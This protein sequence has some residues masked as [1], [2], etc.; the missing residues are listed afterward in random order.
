VRY[1]TA[2]N[3]AKYFKETEGIQISGIT[4]RQKL[5]QAEIIGKSARDKL[6]RKLKFLFYSEADVRSAC[7]D[8]LQN[9]PQADESGFFVKEGKKYSTLRSWSKVFGLSDSTICSRIQINNPPSIKGKV[10]GGQIY[11]FYSELSIRKICADLIQP[12]PKADKN[13][14][15]EQD[16][17]RC[18]TIGSWSKMFGMSDMPITTRLKKFPQDSIKGKDNGGNVH[19]FYPESVIRQICA[20][21]LQSIP[22]AD[23]KGFFEQEGQK[24]GTTGTLAKALDISE[25]TICSRIQIHTPSSIKGKMKGAICEFYS[26]SILRQLCSD[27]IQPLPRADA[28]GFFEQDGERCGT[29]GSWSKALGISAPSISSRIQIHNPPSIKGKVKCGQ[30]YEFYSELSIREI[31]SD[32]LQPLPQANENG[33]FVKDGQRYGTI[34]TWSK[35]L[36]ISTRSIS[37]HIQIHKPPSIKGKVKGGQIYKFY[38]ESEILKLC[39][40]CLEPLPQADKNGFFEQEDQKYGTMKAWSKFLWISHNAI[41]ARVKSYKPQNIQGKTNDGRI[42]I[43]YSES[44]I[45]QICADLLAKRESKEPNPKAA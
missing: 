24:Y 35:A 19:D 9:I 7:N 32:L 25:A 6:K 16:G 40:N 18:G 22:E 15:F 33:F 13:G 3:W 34:V 44:A 45:R 43:F 26:E 38:P 23:E 28:N 12:L 11:E 41:M 36:G 1:S 42:F 29:I 20:D 4:I 30:I 5:K 17:E 2:E 27:L 37:S 31:C 39:S 10:K 21:L 14:F 8:L